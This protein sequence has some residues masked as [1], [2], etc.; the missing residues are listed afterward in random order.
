MSDFY[1]TYIKKIKF[2]M[3]ENIEKHALGNLLSVAQNLFT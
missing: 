1:S 2:K 3:Y